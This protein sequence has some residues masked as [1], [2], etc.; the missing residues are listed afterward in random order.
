MDICAYLHGHRHVSGPQIP[1]LHTRVCAGSPH[2]RGMLQAHPH[3]M[4][5]NHEYQA[6]LLW[7]TIEEKSIYT[8]L[9]QCGV[10]RLG[11]QE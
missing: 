3:L 9:V 1:E 6:G 2:Q 11:D 4:N 7:Q 5:C 8:Y 10:C